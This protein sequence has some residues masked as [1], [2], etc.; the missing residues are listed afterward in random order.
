[1]LINSFQ[2]PCSTIFCIRGGAI[3][4][5]PFAN[6]LFM[7]IAINDA[8]AFCPL[9]QDIIDALAGEYSIRNTA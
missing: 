2:S 4:I 7:N 3:T 6:L 8:L 1:M 5:T 9:P